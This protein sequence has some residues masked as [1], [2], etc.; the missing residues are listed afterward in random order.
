MSSVSEMVERDVHG[1]GAG[2][3]GDLSN[4][5]WLTRIEVVALRGKALGPSESQC[6]GRTSREGA[7]SQDHRLSPRPCVGQ[8]VNVEAVYSQEGR[9]A[10]VQEMEMIRYG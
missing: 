8:F 4:S 3:I 5:Y 2:A 6:R 7:Q 1:G 9:N 10:A